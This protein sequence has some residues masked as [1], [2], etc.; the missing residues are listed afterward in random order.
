[1]PLQILAIDDSRTMRQILEMTFAGEDAE[2]VT[3]DSGDA[4]LRRV[5]ERAV[6]VVL[7]DASLPAPDGY[8]VA[9]AVKSDPATANTAVI[10]LASQQ[11]PY[12]P[13]RGR[14]AGVDDHVSKPFDSQVLI[15]KVVQVLGRARAKPQGAAAAPPP[16]PPPQSA[17]PE[18]LQVDLDDSL[19]PPPPPSAP[20]PSLTPTPAPEPPAPPAPLAA[21]PTPVPE[22]APAPAPPTPPPAVEAAAARAT[23]DGGDVAARLTALGLTQ[24]QV[25]GV[26]ALSREVIERVVWEVVP[27]LA[28]T[29]I[30]EEIQRLTRD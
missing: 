12:D 23:A 18:E 9:L 22:P 3:V 16:V 4:A 29:I 21:A 30:R 26:L 6:D 11:R 8:E 13:N 24:E 20:P 14:D 1:M 10:V 5:K 15:D 19:P 25:S 17:P 27:D 28:E 2:V 7:A